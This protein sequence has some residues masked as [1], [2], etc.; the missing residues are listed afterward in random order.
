VGASGGAPQRAIPEQAK[1]LRKLVEELSSLRQER[2]R[3]SGGEPPAAKIVPTFVGDEQRLEEEETTPR[4][5]QAE[6][7]CDFLGLQV[8]ALLRH[9]QQ[10]EQLLDNLR[11]DSPGRSLAPEAHRRLSVVDMHRQATMEFNELDTSLHT[12]EV[13]K[14]DLDREVER[15]RQRNAEQ[16]EQLVA[17]QQHRDELLQELASLHQ[18]QAPASTNASVAHYEGSTAWTQGCATASTWSDEGGLHG[19]ASIGTFGTAAQSA[20]HSAQS[21]AHSSA[22]DGGF[23]FGLVD[24]RSTTVITRELFEKQKRREAREKEKARARLQDFLHEDGAAAASKTR[25]HDRHRRDKKPPREDEAA[26]SR[27]RDHDHRHRRDRADRPHHHEAHRPQ[28]PRDEDA[29]LWQRERHRSELRVVEG[30]GLR[31][32]GLRSGEQPVPSHPEEPRRERRHRG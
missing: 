29:S 14:A 32:H 26:D 31:P 1:L 13:Q 25:D 30:A 15:L 18:A 23:V 24:P 10:V 6:R 22:D 19:R 2:N 16:A 20:A 7:R 5:R 11:D 4:R 28:R 8:Q 17:T 21:A 9:T 27:A 3:L 12:I